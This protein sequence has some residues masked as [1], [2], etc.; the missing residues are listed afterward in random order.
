MARVTVEDCLEK[1]DNRF[2]LVMLASKRVKQL[3]KGA[4]PLIDNKAANKNVVVSLREIAVGKVGYELT[5][6]KAK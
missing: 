5:S 4:A 2:L 1:V 6:R 3:Y